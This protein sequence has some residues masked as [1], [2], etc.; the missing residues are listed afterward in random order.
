MLPVG[1]V[2]ARRDGGLGG[3]DMGLSAVVG[4]ARSLDSMG[5][6]MRRGQVAGW[7]M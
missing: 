7:V 5:G 1:A 3:G 4:R 2:V 6:I